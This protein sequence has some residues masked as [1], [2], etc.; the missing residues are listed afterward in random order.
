MTSAK[1]RFQ[2]IDL[3]TRVPSFPG[4]YGAIVIRAKRGPVNTPR[5]MTS[6]RQLLNT[7]TP[8]GRVEVGYDLAHYSALSFL[9]KSD[10]L[11]VVRAANTAY[12]AGASIK[13]STATT[14]NQ[15][16]PS[17]QNL[18]NPDAY[19]FDSNPDAP[20]VSEVTTLGFNAIAS[21]ALLDEDTTRYFSLSQPTGDYYVWFNVTDGTETQADPAVLGKV[22]IEVAV[23]AADTS[24]QLASKAQVA[25]NAVT[26]FTATVL[27]STVTV[28]NDDAGAVDN[29]LDD[30]L[31]GVVVTVVTEGV[32]A[33][34]LIDELFMIH[35][36]DEGAWG[37]DV[38][39]KIIVNPDIVKEEDSFIIEVYTKDNVATPVESH[40]VSR[41]PSKLDGFGVNI[42]I[43][44]VLQGSSYIRAKDNVGIDED[45]MPLPQNTVLFLNA[46]DDGLA[47]TDSQ[48]IEAVNTLRNPDRLLMTVL[49][50]GGNATPAYGQELEKIC[51]L[52]TGR[53]DCVAILS[54]PFV[55]EA[56]A[57]YLAD[58]VD[59]RKME[60]NLNSS[61][62]A[63]YSPHV[64]IFDKFNNRQIF[65]APDGFAGGAISFTAANFEMWYP[66]AGFTRGKFVALDLRRRFESGEMD[67]LQ[68]SE[69]NPLRFVPGKGLVIWGQHTL[70][71]RPSALRDLNVRLLL[72][73]IEPAVKEAL[74]NFLFELNDAATRSLISSLL[75]DYLSGIQAGRGV[76][77]YQ[78]VCD[79]SNNTANDIDAG[80]LVVDIFLKPT[81]AVKEIPVRVV[82]TATG[83]SFSDAAAAIG[84]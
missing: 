70:L 35:A 34:N 26:G 11:W 83:L 44:E 55:K 22:G 37:N 41:L 8:K 38:G 58:I 68:N 17:G 75:N 78:V 50:D 71:S 79:S 49:M 7:F 30:G 45:V 18:S 29:A 62:A 9:E 24:A 27:G 80:R 10:K 32:D 46:G 13:E 5:L 61:F 21:G 69:I 42:Y 2:E 25:I 6:D 20:G 52:E 64:K 16:L 47:V 48:M 63:L 19:V 53:G 65:I 82:I 12:Y 84:G 28:T 56:S 77:E 60:L 40:V 59:Y 39:I 3:S 36:A 33:V 66:P 23:L 73:V 43:E 1:V 4:V 67:F 76:Q 51:S 31:S 57:N 81:R 15:P 74:Q 72:I 54:V 14:T